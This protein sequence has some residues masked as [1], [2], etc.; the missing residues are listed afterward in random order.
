MTGC[1][2]VRPH[3]NETDVAQRSVVGGAE[4]H[5][6]VEA[7]EELDLWGCLQPK[8]Q[9]RATSESTKLLRS[10]FADVNVPVFPAGLRGKVLNPS[11]AALI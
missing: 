8:T 5:L 4:E 10:E 9:G 7:G 2:L 11:T 6:T 1:D 3:Y